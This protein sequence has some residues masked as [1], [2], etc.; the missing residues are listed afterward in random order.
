MLWLACEHHVVLLCGQSEDF[1]AVGE[2]IRRRKI[3][4]TS[5]HLAQQH[6]QVNADE[7]LCGCRSHGHCREN[8]AE[9]LHC[10]NPLHGQCQNTDCQQCPHERCDH[11]GWVTF[12]K[13]FTSAEEIDPNIMRYLFFISQLCNRK[14]C[15][16]RQ[17]NC[18]Q[19]LCAEKLLGRPQL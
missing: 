10:W 1:H 2:I 13:H 18:A 7:Q 16:L 9:K 11:R 4:G 12:H 19:Q 17:S 15:H 8:V 3:A 6:H 14:L 5:A